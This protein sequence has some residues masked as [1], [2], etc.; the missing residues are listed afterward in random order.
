M[1]YH[2]GWELV[3]GR[4]ATRGHGCVGAWVSLPSAQHRTIGSPAGGAGGTLQSGV[5]PGITA[6]GRGITPVRGPT[7]P[8]SGLPCVSSPKERA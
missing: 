6:E 2:V 4:L 5:C 7:Q 8:P 3:T 1:I